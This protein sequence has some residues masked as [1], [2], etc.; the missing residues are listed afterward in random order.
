MTTTTTAPGVRDDEIT[1][2]F[3]ADT[4]AI[5]WPY[6]MFDRWR[7]HGALRWA[8]GPA[9]VVT[10]YADVKALMSG[11]LPVGNDG[12]ARGSLA[13]GTVS[14]LPARQH[15]IFHEIMEFES[16]FMSRHDGA[17]HL[18]LR[19]I[20]SR[21]FTGRRIGLLRDAVQSHVDELCEELAADP[22]PDFKR[23]LADRLPVRVI[24]DLLGVPQADRDMIWE[25][26]EAI[27]AHFTI[28]EQSLDAAE[29]AIT[30]FRGY[31][32]DMVARLRRTGD[33][34]D[35]ARTLLGRRDEEA[36]TET[37]LQAMY[38]LILFGGSETTT[39]LLGN[40]FRALQ[41]HR[42]Q[43][44][45]LVADPGQVRGAVDE[46][47]RYD[48]PLQFLPRVA[49]ADFELDG[50][51]VRAGD[52]VL[53]VIGAANRDPSVF[54]D[55]ARL[56]LLRPTRNEHLALAFGSHYCLGAALARLEGEVVFDTLVRRFPRMR[57]RGGEPPYGGSAMLRK[58][59]SQ[60]VDPGPDRGR[61]PR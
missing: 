17:S 53:A 31:L 50:L 12:H 8:A 36:M 52:T 16:N 56:D 5:R 59:T 24:V 26:A 22:A 13:D 3:R 44:D 34:P 35:L 38:L 42:D 32:A 18:R 2:F 14:R 21:A 54:P 46:L 55:P 23:H 30:A 20:A 45:L 27:A 48:S 40:G 41:D 58:I 47:L 43:W 37:E 7:G 39:N 60:P 19:R 33:G 4:D 1:A 9:V 10:R 57:L 28:S 49:Q 15:R 51:P 29:A 25:W 11:E 61:V 6:P